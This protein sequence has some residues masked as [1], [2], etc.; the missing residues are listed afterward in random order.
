VLRPEKDYGPIMKW[1]GAYAELPEGS[2][3]FVC[4]DDVRYHH[5]YINLCV[6]EAA[7]I[8]NEVDRNR[9]LFNA[10]LFD[11]LT[12]NVVFFGIDLLW[13]VHGVFV[14]QNFIAKVGEKFDRTSPDCCLRIDDDVVSVIARDEGYKKVGILHGL[15]VGH[16]LRTYQSDSL[17]SSYNKAQDR[18]NCHS[19]I[20]PVYGDNLLIT[21]IVL[22]C[23]LFVLILGTLVLGVWWFRFGR[24]FP[25]RARAH[26]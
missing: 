19:R 22:S 26:S 11:N 5:G 4:D 23:L 24:H 8:T 7:K 25:V 2:W 9:S 3:V 17:C 13:G 1:I 6:S 18:H 16:A 14:P 15:D 20:N 21:V 10:D 12:E